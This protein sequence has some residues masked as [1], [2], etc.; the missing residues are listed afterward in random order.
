MYTLP[1]NLKF[2]K[3]GVDCRLSA[4]NGLFQEGIMERRV[5]AEITEK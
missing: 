2:L 4:K 5:S 1:S 3:K